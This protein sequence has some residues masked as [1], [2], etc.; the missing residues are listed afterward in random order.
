MY[1]QNLALKAIKGRKGNYGVDSS[2]RSL[3][4]VG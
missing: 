4:K 2:Y 1:A 3:Q